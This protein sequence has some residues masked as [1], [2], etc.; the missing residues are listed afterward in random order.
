MPIKGLEKFR[1]KL[2]SY[3]GKRIFLMLLLAIT[4][5]LSGI[6]FILLLDILSRMIPTNLVLQKLEPILPILGRAIVEFIGFFCVFS[7]W[8][9]KSMYLKASQKFAYQKAL[10]FAIIGIPLVFA[11]VISIYVPIEFLPP[12][13]PINETT[14]VLSS[15][16]LSDLLGISI[17]IDTMIRI[18]GSLF[19]LLLGLLTVRSAFLTFGIDYMMVLY[20]YYPEESQVQQHEIYSVLRHPTYA[21]GLMIA[22]G[23]FFARFSIY[24]L[25]GFGMVLI[26]FLIHINFVEEKELIERF[27]DSYLKYRSKVPAFLIRPRNLKKFFKFLWRP[28]SE[29]HHNTL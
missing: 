3:K 10:K 13:L 17:I 4:S 24:S 28:K 12:R 19:W 16:I 26:G 8:K 5:F 23:G 27:G 25:I 18:I 29:S 7:V 6:G 14:F 22:L 15:S 20:L 9:R 1:E 11:A 21:A 2:P